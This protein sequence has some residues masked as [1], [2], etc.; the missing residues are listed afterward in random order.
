MAVSRGSVTSV[1]RVP[2]HPACQAS[3]TSSSPT[4]GSGQLQTRSR[5]LTD[6]RKAWDCRLSRHAAGLRAGGFLFQPPRLHVPS[7][8]P[9]QRGRAISLRCP[10]AEKE[11]LG[12]GPCSLLPHSPATWLFVLRPGVSQAP[13]PAGQPHIRLP[14]WGSLQGH[15]ESS[16]SHP[17]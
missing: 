14:L 8:L 6:D 12:R 17:Q 5:E 13:A 7:R 4:L 15:L 11:L 2:C 16:A 1:T 3:K 9:L 10:A